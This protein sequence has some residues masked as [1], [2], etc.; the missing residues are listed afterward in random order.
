[1][2]ITT[3]FRRT[4]AVGAPLV[5][6]LA[7]TMAAMTPASASPAG[8]QAPAAASG[9]EAESCSG[10]GLSAGSTTDMT[11]VGGQVADQL[12]DA[13]SAAVTSGEI[14]TAAPRTA[15][16]LDKAKVYTVETDGPTYTSVTV[17]VAGGYS[18]VSNLTVVF[19]DK[20]DIVQSGETL[21][22]RNDAG[23]FNISSYADGKLVKSNDT[24][25]PFMTNAELLQEPDQGTEVTTMGVGS[26][27]ACVVAVLGV[28]GAVGYLIVGA[29][30]GAC[31]IPLVG[32]AICVACIGAYA[33]VGGASITAVASCFK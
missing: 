5:L 2:S 31:T 29:C 16:S 6:V 12:T 24:D 33:V 17:P 32:T 30:A 13:V 23:N 8:G 26:T 22:S 9:S 20:G 10:Q 21:I 28:T 14:A 19:D 27:V 11:Q 15:L 25:R 4:R 1:M 7:V 3:K 18:T